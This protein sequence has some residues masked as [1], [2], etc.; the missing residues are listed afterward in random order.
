MF[1]DRKAALKHHPD[2]VPGEEKAKSAERFKK[3]AEAYAILSDSSKRA[4]YDEELSAAERLKPA[5]GTRFGY[6]SG[7]RPEDAGE[8][9]FGFSLGGSPRRSP[10]PMGRS[11]F[12]S[13]MPSGWEAGIDP[14]GEC[15]LSPNRHQVTK[16]TL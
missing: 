3:V 4:I 2:R 15:F 6:G 10:S 7:L 11:G 14:F 13:R 1:A 16:L 12:A 8:D 5:S 9:G